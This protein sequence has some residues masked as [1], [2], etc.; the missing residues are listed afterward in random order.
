[1]ATVYV[2]TAGSGESYRIERVYLDGD[3][4]YGFAQD[5]QRHCPGGDRCRWRNGRSVPRRRSTTARTGGRSGG[6]ACRS[7]KRR[8]A[9]AAHR[10]GRTVRRLR[11][12][13]SNGGLGTLC[14]RPRWCAG[15][16]PGYPGSRWRACSK[17]KVEELFWD[18]VTQVRAELAGRTQEI[19]SARCHATKRNEMGMSGSTLPP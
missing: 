12:S 5:V 6:R 3:L 14:P 16:W 18:T 19:I 8:G 2:V 17:D 9:A 4:A 13:A 7:A 15:N 1:M 11:H 10:R